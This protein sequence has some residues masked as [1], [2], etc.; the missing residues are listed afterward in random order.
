[1][2]Y[3]AQSLPAPASRSPR[4][5][6]LDEG[7]IDPELIRLIPRHLAERHSVVPL[8]RADQSLS[9]AMANPDDLLAIDEI[10]RLTGCRVQSVLASP[11]EISRAIVRFYAGQ[12]P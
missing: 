6:R 7:M 1:M 5:R 12:M 8:A 3:A 2:R 11:D 9:L 4:H 10:C